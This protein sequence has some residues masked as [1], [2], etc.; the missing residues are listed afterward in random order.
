MSRLRASILCDF[1]QVRDGVLFVASGGITR[2][3][4]TSVPANLRLYLALVIEVGP[5]ELDKVHE[6]RVR[7]TANQSVNVLV[8]SSFSFGPM[9]SPGTFAGE[10]TQFPLVVDIKAELPEWGAYD[11]A[12]TLD[13]EPEMPLTFWLVNSAAGR[14]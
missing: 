11:I 2:V 9:Q 14:S 3:A 10:A 12:V 13:N 4:A 8:N 5:D 6:F 7:I 1:A